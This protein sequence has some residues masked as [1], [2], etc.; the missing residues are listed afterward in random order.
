MKQSASLEGQEVVG[1]EDSWVD[2]CEHMDHDGNL[3]IEV[4]MGA[5]KKQ[6]ICNMSMQL[7]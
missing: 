1:W 3:D 6:L 7:A 4:L 2:G 5:A